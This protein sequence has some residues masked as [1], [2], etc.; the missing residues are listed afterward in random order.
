MQ[1][2]LY[3][4]LGHACILHLPACCSQIQS[5]NQFY[6]ARRV[7]LT[8]DKTQQWRY[9]TKALALH[10]CIEKVTRYQLC[11]FALKLSRPRI[12]EPACTGKD[13]LFV[14]WR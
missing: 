3:I 5:I 14:G 8:R 6:P 2:A 9:A 7:P 10:C 1:Y 12:C 13:V 11:N 4:E